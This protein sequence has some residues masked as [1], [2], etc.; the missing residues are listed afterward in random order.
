MMI[1]MTAAWPQAF[2]AVTS[3][4]PEVIE[5]HRD[6]CGNCEAQEVSGNGDQRETSTGRPESRSRARNHCAIWSVLVTP[7]PV[8]CSILRIR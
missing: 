5:I 2:L 7:R 3:V 4:A 8:I 1:L 6:T